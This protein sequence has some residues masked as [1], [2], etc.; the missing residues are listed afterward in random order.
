MLTSLIN[1]FHYCFM[2][3]CY[4]LLAIGSM[5]VFMITM[6]LVIDFIDNHYPKLDGINTI[7][8]CLCWVAFIGIVCCGLITIMYM[9]PYVFVLAILGL[10]IGLIILLISVIVDTIKKKIRG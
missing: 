6:G 1:N 10:I 5:I 9:L 3:M 8:G 2:H 7:I 4:N